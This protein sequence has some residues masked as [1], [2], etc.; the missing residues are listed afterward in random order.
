MGLLRQWL[1]AGDIAELAL[2]HGDTFTIRKPI[3]LTVTRG[4]AWITVE[5]E[6]DDLFL[7]AGECFTSPRRRLT[8]VQA[9]PRCTIELTNS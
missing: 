1:G 6:P 8:V 4:R 5:G 7:C 2:E 3:S 9:D